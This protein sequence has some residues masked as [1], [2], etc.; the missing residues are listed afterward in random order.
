MP[1]W[2]V[3][4][5]S[6]W[7]INYCTH[8]LCYYLWE[9]TTVWLIDRAWVSSS[10]GRDTQREEERQRQNNCCQGGVLARRGEGQ[11]FAYEFSIK[12]N[13][14]TSIH[15][16]LCEWQNACRNYTLLTCGYAPR[17]PLCLPT[18]HLPC[19]PPSHLCRLAII[20]TLWSC[21]CIDMW[22]VFP[23]TNV[24]SSSRSIVF[25]FL[26]LSISL[27]I[28]SYSYLNNDSCA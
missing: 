10:R 8:I 17:L 7:V 19:F 18:A 23:V 28:Y 24:T 4:D 22:P 25:I 9:A 16:S 12:C 11:L 26:F 1:L 13:E 15:L 20:S 2:G 27:F 6:V 3:N 21:L 5:V 14:R